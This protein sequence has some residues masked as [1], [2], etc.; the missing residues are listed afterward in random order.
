MNASQ[1]HLLD[2]YR[3]AQRGEAPP[4]RPDVATVRTVREILLW[5]RFTSVLTDP[6]DRFPARALRAVRRLRAS[7]RHPRPF[8]PGTGALRRTPSRIA[9]RTAG[10]HPARTG[11]G[12]GRRTGRRAASPCA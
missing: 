2:A 11:D 1:Q 12:A 6:A 10:A 7:F 9:V 4:V 5:R 3:A 8:H